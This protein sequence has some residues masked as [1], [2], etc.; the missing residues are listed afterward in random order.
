MSLSDTIGHLNMTY[1]LRNGAYAQNRTYLKNIMKKY[2]ISFGHQSISNEDIV[3]VA[4]AI[5][6]FFLFIIAFANIIS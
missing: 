6:I 3:V 1:E 5:V 2:C 4:I